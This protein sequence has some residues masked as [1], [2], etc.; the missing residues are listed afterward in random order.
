MQATL[1]KHASNA[2]AIRTFVAVSIPPVDQD[3]LAGIIGALEPERALLKLVQPD[4]LHI[5]LRFLGLVAPERVERVSAAA[6]ATAGAAR[7]FLVTIAGLGAFPNERA[8]RVLWAGILANEGLSLLRDLARSLDDSLAAEGF[9][10][11]SRT[12][13]PHITLARTRDRI[14]ADE[15][16]RVASALHRLRT[17]DIPARSFWVRDVIVM[18]SDPGPAGPRYTPMLTAPLS[19]APAVG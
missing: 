12:F 16:E 1:S 19:G 4:L 14:T 18:R 15:R 6:V 13:S 9:E 8:P 3:M 11:E 2:K 5:T 17:R 7:P 10:R